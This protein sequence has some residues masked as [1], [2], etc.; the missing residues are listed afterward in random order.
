M[1]PVRLFCWHFMAY[2]HLPP[3][4]DGARLEIMAGCGYSP[5]LEKPGEAEAL[6]AAFLDG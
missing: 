1:H 3:D 6:V 5:H 4:F 2:P